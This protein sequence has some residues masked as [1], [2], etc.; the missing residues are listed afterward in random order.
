MILPYADDTNIC[1]LNYEE[2][3]RKLSNDTH[4]VLN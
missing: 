2:A 1:S 4:I 3:H